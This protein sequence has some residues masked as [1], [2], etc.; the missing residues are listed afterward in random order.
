M[1]NYRRTHYTEAAAER[2]AETLREHS[3]AMDIEIQVTRD[4]FGQTVY[5]VAWN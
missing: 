4:G 2:F 5:N 1:H 3:E